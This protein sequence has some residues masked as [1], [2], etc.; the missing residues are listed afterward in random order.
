MRRTPHR[1]VPDPYA[2]KIG[3]RVRG[4]RRERSQSFSALVTKTGLG[5]GYLSELE[6]G[7]VVPSVGPLRR[8]ARALSVSV[9]DLVL[10]G[11]ERE[12]VFHE[13]LGLSVRDL[14]KVR[15]LVSRLRRE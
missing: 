5:K 4:L 10:G 1:T 12:R 15:K 8:L 7:L 13:M 6:R 11:T 9:A 14:R 3:T 2:A